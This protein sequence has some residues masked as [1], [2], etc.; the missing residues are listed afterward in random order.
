MAGGAHG[1]GQPSPGDH[2]QTSYRL[3]LFGDQLEHGRAPWRD[4]YSFRPETEPTVSLGWWP[5]SLLY[6]PL[7]ALF[8]AVI[9][10]N[11]F[12]LITFVLAGLA[13]LFWL[14]ELGLPPWAALAG[15]LAFEIAPYRVVQSEGHLLG[16]ISVLLPFALWAFERARRGSRRWLVLTGAA[17]VSFPLAGQLHPAIGAVVFFAA[18]ALARTR[19]RRVLVGA[20]GA[21]LAA[22]AVGFLVQRAIIS[23]SLSEGGRSLK[24][25]RRYQADWID[26]LSRDKRDGGESFVLLGWL[27]PVLAAAGLVV[28][29]RVRRYAL[30]AVLGFGALVPILL[31]VGTHLPLYEPLWHAFKPFRYPRVPERLMPVACLAIAALVAFAVSRLRWRLAP[32]VLLVALFL[33]LHVADFRASA[34]DE[35]NGV[36]ARVRDLPRGALLELP[37]FRAGVHYAGDYLYYTQQSQRPHVSGYTTFAPKSADE[38]LSRL[39][40]LN[41]GVWSRELDV[42]G[43]RYVTV[44]DGLFDQPVEATEPHTSGPARRM[45]EAHGFRAISRDG[46]V[47]LYARP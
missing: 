31:A 44:N 37:V 33:D 9:A 13:A 29:V 4:E 25:V 3:W 2:L 30:A 42:L 38:L 43:V 46:R 7:D 12:V 16:A 40:V 23:G 6:W 24:E 8:D 18:Y 21:V 5:Y 45:L 47:T 11:V 20:L 34:A 39:R 41:R 28:L 26:F 19:E 35:H 10:W 1:Y 27:T 32:L 17:L 36:Y 14:L 15:G 22:T